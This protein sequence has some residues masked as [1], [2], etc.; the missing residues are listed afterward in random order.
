MDT[1]RRIAAGQLL[2]AAVTAIGLVV[3]M[4]MLNGKLDELNGKFDALAG[5]V[6]AL[7]TGHAAHVNRGLHAR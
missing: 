5:R 4:W 2:L 1:D 6:D 7:E 3:G